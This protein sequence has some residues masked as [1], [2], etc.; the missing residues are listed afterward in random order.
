MPADHLV[1]IPDR[2]QVDAAI[3]AFEL[4]EEPRKQ[5]NLLVGQDLAERQ[6]AFSDAFPD[7]CGSR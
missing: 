5:V 1:D 2:R 3:P 4:L 6:C 7:H